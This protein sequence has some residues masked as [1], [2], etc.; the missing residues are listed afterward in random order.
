[1]FCN[2]FWNILPANICGIICDTHMKI[3][4]KADNFPIILYLQFHAHSLVLK[5]Y[6]KLLTNHAKDLK[7]KSVKLIKA[8]PHSSN[9]HPL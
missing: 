7:I 6:A 9:D 8:N 3:W 1:M 5:Y 2:C 4:L